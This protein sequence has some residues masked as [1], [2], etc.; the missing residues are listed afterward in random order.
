MQIVGRSFLALALVLLLLIANPALE[1]ANSATRPL[2]LVSNERTKDGARSLQVAIDTAAAGDTLVVKGTCFGNSTV[3]KDLTLTGVSNK[4]FGVATLDGSGFSGPILSLASS[5]DNLNVAIYDL[6]ITHGAAFSAAISLDGFLGHSV[7]LTRTTVIDNNGSGILAN[8][9]SGGATLVDSTVKGNA[10]AGLG[11]RMFVRLIRSTVSNNGGV[12]VNSFRAGAFLSDS[13][14]SGNG[15]AGIVVGEGSALLIGSTVSGNAGPGIDVFDG[16]ADLVNSTV[17]GNATS[18]SGGGIN[19]FQAT[20]Y[21]T[22]STVSGNTAVLDG[23]GINMNEVTL[24]S[25]TVSDNTAGGKGGGIHATY[26]VT[27]TDSTVSGNTASSGGGIF[28]EP[29]GTAVLTGTNTFFN[30][31]PEDC[32]G[33]SGC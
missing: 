9:P 25:S 33:V 11:G 6:V 32:V 23:G 28:L 10:G 8:E 3:D 17:S 22:D 7:E 2:C 13:T 27:L 20:A 12:G 26:S 14:V 30:N 19:G 15:R 29:G 21:L 24:T 4:Q 16:T 1:G 5:F 18:G 31:V